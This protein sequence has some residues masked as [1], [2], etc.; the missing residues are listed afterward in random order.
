MV[1]TL[2]QLISA[3]EQAYE[4]FGDIEVRVAY[5]PS[6][7]FELS[8]NRTEVVDDEEGREFGDPDLDHSPV[9]YIAAPE[10]VGYLPGVVTEILGW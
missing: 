4:D 3:A 2:T 5:Q 10:Q 9:F 6:Y 1:M 7:P 8:V